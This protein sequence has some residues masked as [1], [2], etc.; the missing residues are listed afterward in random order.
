[1][2][3]DLFKCTI[4]ASGVYDLPLMHDDGD[5]PKWVYG[6]DY[7]SDA[8][9]NDELNL[10]TFSPSYNVDRLKVPVLL[11]HGSADEADER[12]PISQAESLEKALKANKNPYETLYIDNEYHCFIKEGNRLKAMET[13]V[14]F[15]N[16]HIGS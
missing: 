5:V 12:T 8:I 14:E 1:M 13:I 2:A 9:G 10:K 15:L 4:G 11:I 16:E 7:L 6:K 3:P